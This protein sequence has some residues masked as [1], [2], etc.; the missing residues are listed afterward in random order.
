VVA[1][2]SNEGDEHLAREARNYQ[3]FERHMFEE[4]SGY[5]VL[6]PM[7]DPVPVVPLVPRF[8]GYYVPEDEDEEEE[9]ETETETMEKISPTT[10]KD[11][12]M[13]LGGKSEDAGEMNE[14]NGK[15]T[16]LD[17]DASDD[18][19]RKATKARLE[20]E[21]PTKHKR[22]PLGYIS[23]IL[24]LEDCGREIDPNDL[25]LDQKHE[26]LSFIYRFH[27]IGWVHGSVYV[28]N[29]LMQ[30][31]PLDVPPAERSKKTPSF[32][33]IDFGRSHH[34]DDTE[35]GNAFQ[36]DRHMEERHMEEIFGLGLFS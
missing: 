16:S 23:P 6:P 35:I 3:R 9:D 32:R 18:E 29:I 8:Y 15:R 21:T 17:T 28:R 34:Y 11:S 14:T 10:A 20:A 5:N 25:T 36:G 7:H 2:L 13:V 12:G 24:L 33:L 1:K 22:E 30:P 19:E 31:G 26:A 27:H 4:W